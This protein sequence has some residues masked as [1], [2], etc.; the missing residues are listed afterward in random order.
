MEGAPGNQHY[1][2]NE[3]A[4]DFLLQVLIVRVLFVLGAI[5]DP[6]CFRR[7]F[8][9][10]STIPAVFRSRE[11]DEISWWCISIWHRRTLR[12]FV[13]KCQI[14]RLRMSLL[15]LL[16]RCLNG[17]GYGYITHNVPLLDHC[18]MVIPLFCQ[19]PLTRNGVVYCHYSHKANDV[20]C[21]MRRVSSLYAATNSRTVYSGRR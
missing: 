10:S 8:A 11:L 12:S 19:C 18:K 9:G 7:Y 14:N 21:N 4:R 2:R 17:Y 1:G 15:D 5:Q 16:G 3:W 20:C 13:F 6:F